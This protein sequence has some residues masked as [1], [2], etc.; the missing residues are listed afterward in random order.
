MPIYFKPERIFEMKPTRL[1]IIRH[2][3]SALNKIRASSPIFFTDSP[4]RDLFIDTPDHMVPITEEG[5]V[6]ARQTGK[7]LGE[8][9]DIAVHTGYARTKQTLEQIS[10]SVT[11]STTREIIDF[12]ERENGYAYIMTES[13]MEKSFPWNKQYWK[14]VG[15]IFARP[16]GGESLMDVYHRVK[17][18]LVELISGHQ[19][20]NMLLV[21]HGRV[22]SIIRFILE[23][24]SLEEFESFLRDS[25]QSPINCA[26]TTYSFDSKLEATLLSYNKKYW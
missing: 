11:V 21:T 9:Y 2:A 20:E 19:G 13:E 18:A 1:T 10:Y 3:E 22:I 17:P 5:T 12:R 4:T 23:K 7:L 26:V 16:I 15:P 24:W 25:S 14:T 8:S 6:Q